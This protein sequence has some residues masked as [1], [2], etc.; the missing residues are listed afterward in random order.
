MCRFDAIVAPCGH[1]R[2]CELIDALLT[3]FFPVFHSLFLD[4]LQYFHLE[5]LKL[6]LDG[7]E[8]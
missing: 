3:I 4:I 8:N 1:K 6:F 5:T 2:H 7:I